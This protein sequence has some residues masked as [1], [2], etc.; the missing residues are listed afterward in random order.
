MFRATT[1]FMRRS[2][3]IRFATLLYAICLPIAG[4]AQLMP[5][6]PGVPD[7]YFIGF[8]GDSSQRVFERETKLVKS[9]IEV[10]FE[11]S[12][13]S[14]VLVNRDSDSAPA[15]T[16]QTL[17]KAIFDIAQVMDPNEDVLVLHITSHGSKKGIHL[18][19]RGRHLPDLSPN[20]VAQALQ[21]TTLQYVVVVVSA[22]HSGVFIDALQENSR[23]I[24]TAASSE[25]KSYGCDDQRTVTE[26]TQRFYLGNLRRSASFVDAF[27]AAQKLTT[28]EERAWPDALRSHPQQS[29]GPKARAILQQIAK[30]YRTP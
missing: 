17:R 27:D 24:F 25:H 8:A 23:A 22:C 4:F 11:A 14:I 5:Q 9:V 26:F 15:A 1:Y 3:L 7:V 21:G 29:V 6:R 13:R 30:R 12:K 19:H 2:F 16:A 10:G 20:E 28:H 18:S